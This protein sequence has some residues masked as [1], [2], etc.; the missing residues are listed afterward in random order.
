MSVSRRAVDDALLSVS[1][2]AV[3]EEVV[4]PKNSGAEIKSEEEAGRRCTLPGVGVPV[5]TV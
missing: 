1:R 4:E 3:D 2:R 5:R